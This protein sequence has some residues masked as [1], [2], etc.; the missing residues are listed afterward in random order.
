MTTTAI[1]PREAAVSAMAAAA[2][3]LEA[4]LM[5]GCGKPTVDAAA[6]GA[7]STTAMRPESRI[8]PFAEKDRFIHDMSGELASIARD[9]ERLFPGV[10]G[11][12]RSI[13]SVVI[14]DLEDLRRI[15]ADL[16]RQLD[17]ARSADAED[18]QA[19]T[20]A[21]VRDLARLRDGLERSRRR[22]GG[23]LPD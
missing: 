20:T 19:R 12:G 1:T 6:S 14:P 17:A 22:L 2:L 9:F 18:W 3:I 15:A 11:A 21:F 4:A 5:G 8:Y 10:E 23:P 7:P 16:H 13:Q